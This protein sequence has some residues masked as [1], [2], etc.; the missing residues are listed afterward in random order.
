MS[1]V[2]AEAHADE[3]AYLGAPP[4][5][6]RAMGGR[7]P[8][9][10]QWRAISHPLAP[11]CAVAGAGS[12]KT[13]V[14]AARLVYLALVATG[15][16][17]ADHPGALPSEV[18][19]L[20][21]TTKAAEELARRVREATAGLG[22]PESEEAT[23]LT[24]HAFAARLL[25][26][27]GVW[28]G[29]EPGAVL[30]TEAMKWQVVSG[31]LA[32][33]QFEHLEVRTVGRVVEQALALAAQ[34]ADHLVDPERLREESLA[35]A[36]HVEVR[37]AVDRGVR[38]TALRRAELAEL[39]AAYRDRKRELGA[40]DYGD[41]IELAVRL[42]RE[43]PEVG[44]AFRERYRVVLLDEYQDTNV[45]QARLLEALLGPGFPVMAV[46]DPDQNI[47]AW[48]GASLR[49]ILRFPE[50]FPGPDGPAEHRPLYVN[51]RSGSR[52]LEVADAVI[53]K[54]PEERRAPD[55]VLRP[56]P[57][58]GAGRVLA[59]F[60]ADEREEAR[61]IA[62]LV[63]ELVA[64]RPPTEA[65]EP[66]WGDV[67]VLCR[68][69]RLFP[70]VAEILREE[71]V[72]VEVVDLGG[73]LRMP[74]VVDVV[75][76]LRLLDDPGR[77]VA[78]AR[79]LQGPRWRIGYRDLV[80]LARWASAHTRRLVAS[81]PGEDE[82]PGDVVF[83]LAEALD[84][85]D[86]PDLRDLSEEGR[87]RL[88][89]FRAEL[90]ELREVARG[91]LEDLVAEVVERTGLLREL[92]ASD[93]PQAQ[94]ARR[95]LLNFVD[96]VAAF[97]PVEGEASLSTL[98]S[99]LDTA[100]ETEDE[101]EPAQPSEANTVKVLTIHKAKGLEW[102]VVFVPG[103]AEGSRSS[104]FP[105]ASRQP[106]PVTQPHQLPFELRGDA[107]VLPRFD[108]TDLQRFRDE[109][110]ERALEEERRL[111]YVALTRA[112]DVLVVSGAYWYEGPAEPFR[113]G[114]FYLEVRDHPACE[115]L[116]EADCPQ[117]NPLVAARAER[118]RRW[119]PRG[120]VDDADELFP[121]GWHRAA[122][123]AVRDPDAV[124]ARAAALGAAG[125][126]E[127]ERELARNRERA[128]L[129]QAR[130]RSPLPPPVP[131]ALS[132]SSMID[133]VRCPKLFFWS[134]VR[135]LPRRPSRA[136]RLGAEVHR[137]IEL[138]SR[139]QATLIEPEEAP[140]LATEERLGEA[141]AA[142]RLKRAFR[143][144]RFARAVPLYVERPF[145][146]ALEGVVVRGRMDAIFGTPEGPWEVVDYKTGQPP[147]EGDPVAGFQ[148][149]LYALAC[150][151]VWGKRPEDLTLTYFYL[152][153]G[154]EVS[155]PADDPVVTR[156]RVL[157]ALRGAAR[158]R[159][160][161]TPGP[162]CRWCDFLSFCRAGQAFVSEEPAGAPA[163]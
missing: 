110:R 161:P 66:P 98:V 76:W 80:A 130:A 136:A 142:D 43:R 34:C 113:P 81:L 150:T 160:D 79:I 25:E 26:D 6:V 111:C 143:E 133:Y 58:R 63:R 4:E 41:Q 92:E 39:V 132:V 134:V 100:E 139:G 135:P 122:L 30:L 20:T 18:L 21:F 149:D 32:D 35:F 119:P 128:E 118:T 147:P 77:N 13:A 162:Q 69:K 85:L 97:A 60:A 53:G 59:F 46:G 47:Y 31:L 65:G 131:S 157:G 10:Q 73:L 104:L 107:D 9:V 44:R 153:T 88:R 64:E 101:L 94:S 14:M 120:R 138:E 54:V 50:Q 95:N 84:H 74:E 129:I 105:D 8:T 103:M 163:S 106:N 102:P 144:S 61:R 3:A 78:L 11:G 28:G 151:E 109:L 108:G 37:R 154:E 1:D 75:A 93:A 124:A 15:R 40:I 55:K 36:D 126:V 91:P 141:A 137:W 70:T 29:V 16:V 155:R 159:F 24:Y 33:R 96:H 42:V 146:L 52:I 152:S 86:D 90:A 19:C 145:L 7:V 67:A 72:P 38:E 27:Y 22:L 158:G 115:V 17:P 89:E 99:Y 121:E 127:F 57:D 68:K 83:A 112:R 140:D 71:G 51:F 62:R 49:N 82:R 114:T 48:R 156:A 148:L 116:E 87:E 12:G 45:A 5:V 123:E 56:H 125:R 23:V 117:E 2:R